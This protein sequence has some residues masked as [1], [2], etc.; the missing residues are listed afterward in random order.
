MLKYHFIALH[1]R[2]FCQSSLRWSYYSDSNKSTKKGTGKS[3]LF[4]LYGVQGYCIEKN[5]PAFVAVTKRKFKK[6]EKK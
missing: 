2:A 4:A 6:F 1:F 5:A 3:H